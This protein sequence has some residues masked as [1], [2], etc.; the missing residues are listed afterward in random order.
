VV[1]SADRGDVVVVVVVVIDRI[2]VI[3]IEKFVN[4]IGLTIE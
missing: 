4:K 1:E 3:K 2:M